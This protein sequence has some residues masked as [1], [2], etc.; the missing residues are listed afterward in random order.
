MMNELQQMQ[1]SDLDFCLVTKRLGKIETAELSNNKLMSIPTID[2]EVTAALKTTSTS[3]AEFATALETKPRTGAEFAAALKAKFDGVRPI[4][5]DI[6]FATLDWRDLKP[7]KNYLAIR[8]LRNF[9]DRQ[10]PYYSTNVINRSSEPI[11]IDRFG[12]YIKIGRTLVLHTIT[13][14]FFSHQQFQEWYGLAQAE[15]IEPGQTVIDP[16]S[17]SHLGT[18]W[19]YFCTTASGRKFVASSAWNGKSWWQLW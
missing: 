5:E 9:K 11:R 4:A 15:W 8:H 6:I 3:K 13:G 19:A 2:P 17:H 14:G 1:K 16:N 10:K 18:H 12:T 7:G